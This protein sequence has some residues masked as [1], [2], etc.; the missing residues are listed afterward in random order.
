[1]FAVASILA[2]AAVANGKIVPETYTF[3]TYVEVGLNRK[4]VLRATAKKKQ[5]RHPFPSS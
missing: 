3:E 2:L 5:H 1:M 4:G